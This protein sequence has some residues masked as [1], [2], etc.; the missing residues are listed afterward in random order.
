MSIIKKLLFPLRG[1]L[2]PQKCALCG[3]SLTGTEEI[4]LGLCEKCRTMVVRESGQECGVCGKPL[5]SE[6]DICLSCRNGEG[7]SYR[8]MWVLFPYTGIY[9]KLLKA[10]KFS[11]NLSLANFF[12]EK[13][14]EVITENPEL[15]EAV[16]I[17][18]PPRP[19][20][21]KESG[22]DQVEELTKRLIKA[23]QGRI[24]V[25]NCLKRRISKVQKQLNREQRIEN[26][27]GRIVLNKSAPKTAL[28]IDDVIT[29]G[30][31]MEVCCQALK[32][33][34]AEKVYGLCL[35]FD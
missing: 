25:S 1:F 12:A 24:K 10:Y 35:F 15:I 7:H 32:E 26:L 3:L 22:W 4:R 23:G 8:R 31:T 18:V 34:G 27:K 11:K 5:V 6:K 28:V 14:L 29:T 13:I 19:G 33:G 2:F 17:P 9:R 16:I 20:K 30:S 21:V